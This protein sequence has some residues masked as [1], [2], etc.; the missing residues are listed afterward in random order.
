MNTVFEKSKIS[1][2]QWFQAIYYVSCHKKGISA[3]QLHRELGVTEKTAWFMIHRIRKIYEQE[4]KPTVKLKNVMCDECFIGGINRWRHSDK[5]V[6]KSQGR[7]FKDKTPV[8]GMLELGGELRAFVIPSTKSRWIQSQVRKNVEPGSL[9]MTDEWGAYKG[10]GS[11]YFH[12]IVDHSRGEYSRA[13]GVSTN[14]IESAWACLKGAQRIVHNNVARKH[15]QKYVDAFVF[16]FNCRDY[17]IGERMFL[18]MQK[19]YGKRL[20]YANLVA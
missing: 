3:L 10:L 9:L 14:A 4:K 7:S 18:S 5:K 17:G 8:M 13:D 2:M 1:L 15:L 12:E 16:R 6:K 19:S 11:E 20:T